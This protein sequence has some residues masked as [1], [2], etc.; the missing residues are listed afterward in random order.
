MRERPKPSRSSS[1][2]GERPLAGKEAL[3]DTARPGRLVRNLTWLAGGQLSGRLIALAVA[4]YLARALGASAYGRIGVAFAF[5]AYLALVVQAGLDAIGTR[6]VARA[7]A[8]ATSVWRSIV[9]LRLVLAI[10]MYGLL[11]PLAWG[12]PDTALGGRA[13]ALAYGGRMLTL[14]INSAWLLR[15]REKMRSVGVGIVLQQT[16]NAAGI[17][18]LIQSSHSPLV[19]VPLIHVTSELFQATWL[20]LAARKDLGKLSGRVDYAQQKRLLREA[21]PLGV[22]KA[23][24]L[25]FYQGDLLLIAWLSTPEQAGYFL[26]GQKLIVSLVALSILFY[27]NTLPAMSRMMTS[28]LE[29]ANLFRHDL[30]R[31]ALA[32]TLPVA[33]VSTVLAQ[34]IIPLVFGAGFGSAAP[35]F[36]VMVWTLPLIVVSSGLRQQLVVAGFP[37]QLMVAEGLAAVAHI[38]SAAVLIPLWGGWGAAWASLSGEVLQNLFLSYCVRHRL[39]AFPLDRRGMWVVASGAAMGLFLLLGRSQR[40]WALLPGGLFVYGAGLVLARCISAREV[41]LLFSSFDLRRHRRPIARSSR[42]SK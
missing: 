15:G 10:L 17:F 33:V 32:A 24:R 13:L 25:V 28:G 5:V 14:A 1:S 42:P 31:F 2:G 23:L 18:W 35:I 26:V 3:C 11:V 20:F 21:W 16:L 19:L 37:R 7:P 6:E 30:A 22:T 4:I 9:S 39:G 8:A 40:V 12:L 36:S 27:Q 34:S 38:A 29:A 41:R